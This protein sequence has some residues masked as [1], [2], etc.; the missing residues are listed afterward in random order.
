MKNFVYLALI[1]AL[2]TIQ[3]QANVTNA[4]F[5]NRERLDITIKS[6]EIILE[7][8]IPLIPTIQI[9]EAELTIEKPQEVFPY[10]TL[11]PIPNPTITPTP[12]KYIPDIS[13]EKSDSDNPVTKAPRIP[14]SDP[15]IQVPISDPIIEALVIIET[16]ENTQP[17]LPISDPVNEPAKQANPSIPISDPLLDPE[18]NPEIDPK[19]DIDTT[20]TKTTN[21]ETNTT[22]PTD[23]PENDEDK[24]S[25]TT[26]DYEST[27]TE[28][29]ENTEK[30]TLINIDGQIEPQPLDDTPANPDDE[31]NDKPVEKL[32]DKIEVSIDQAM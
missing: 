6:S 17:T 2:L 18:L 31:N 1:T 23:S 4:R 24:T 11:T 20:I 30:D 29:N 25:E 26:K 3:L 12:T 13:S 9:P 14:I 10:I 16:I 22:P 5:N 28:Q 32:N 21:E 8:E 15:I 19:I 7:S 27:E